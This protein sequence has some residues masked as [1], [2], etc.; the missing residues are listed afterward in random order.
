MIL[1]ATLT[2]VNQPFDSIAGDV[3]YPT[4]GPALSIRCCLDS[5]TSAQ[6]WTIDE[7]AIDASAMLYVPLTPLQAAATAAGDSM[8]DTFLKNAQVLVQLDGETS[9]R[10]YMVRRAIPRVG[11]IPH[12]ECFIKAQ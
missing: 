4:S 3:T 11:A 10:T 1:N 6:R 9:A 7:L 12:V 8:T 2:Q 5:P